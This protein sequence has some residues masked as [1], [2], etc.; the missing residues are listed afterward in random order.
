[1]LKKMPV[2]KKNEVLFVK[3]VVYLIYVYYRLKLFDFFLRIYVLGL[4]M[5]SQLFKKKYI[6]LYLQVFCGAILCSQLRMLT[7]FI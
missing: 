2:L 5:N 1:M 3:Q 6:I 7:R 4:F